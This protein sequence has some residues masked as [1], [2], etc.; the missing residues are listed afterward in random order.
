MYKKANLEAYAIAVYELS[1]EM[2]VAHETSLLLTALYK[3]LKNDTIFID[4]L[5][6][7]ETSNEYKFDFIDNIFANFDKSDV[8]KKFLKVVVEHKAVSNLPRI[9]SSYLK[10]VNDH[11]NIKFAKIYSAFPISEDKLNLIKAKLE[12]ELNC[13][14]DIEH[15]I[16]PNIISGIRIKMNS[17]VIE[18]S[19]G[20]SLKRLTKF[21]NLKDNEKNKGGING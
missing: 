4:I 13:L 1:V 19:L 6:N 9:I 11:L 15:R 3:E 16:D 20:L 8:M 17:F 10:L 5:K 21:I 7:N 14:V 12:K 18:N 2:N